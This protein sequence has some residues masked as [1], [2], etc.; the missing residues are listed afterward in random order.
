MGRLGDSGR[1]VVARVS[2][3]ELAAG[4]SAIRV[5]EC[6]SLVSAGE[7]RST[8]EENV[9]EDR[10]TCKVWHDK[11]SGAIKF[12]IKTWFL[13]LKRSLPTCGSLESRREG[14]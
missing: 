5:A 1:G 6:S 11:R 4:E 3:E 12:E 9:E 8:L 10:V 7:E 13:N 2:V 14:S